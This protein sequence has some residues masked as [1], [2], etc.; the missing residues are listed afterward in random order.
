MKVNVKPIKVKFE[1]EVILI[2]IAKELAINEN[3]MTSQLSES[4]LNYYLLCRIRDKYIKKRDIIAQERDQAYNQAWTYLKDSNDRWNNDY[5]TSKAKVNKKYLSL[6]QKY[7]RMADKA[8][9]FIA[10]CRAYED[11]AN[12]LRTL[13]ANLRKSL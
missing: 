1:G 6:V 10:L 12:I 2:D 3:I 7:L 13:N 11:R 9:M 4:P 5:V 8:S